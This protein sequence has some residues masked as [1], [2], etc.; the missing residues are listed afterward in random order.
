MGDLDVF[1]VNG[2][3]ESEDF[4]I[5]GRLLTPKITFEEF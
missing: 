5:A 2:G 3:F 1:V 4:R